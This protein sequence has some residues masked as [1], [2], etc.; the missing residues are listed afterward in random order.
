MAVSSQCQG[1]GIG[2]KLLQVAIQFARDENYKDIV[3]TTTYN[4]QQA[5]R[6]YEKN[7]FVVESTYLVRRFGIPFFCIYS[8][9]YMN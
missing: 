1:L 3:L 4:H 6:F 7:G 9:R 5:M 2:K 8:L